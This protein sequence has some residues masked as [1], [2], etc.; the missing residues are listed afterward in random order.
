MA[1]FALVVFCHVDNGF[2]PGW[3]HHQSTQEVWEIE[4]T[5][6]SALNGC[7]V[8]GCLVVIGFRLAL[9]SLVSNVLCWMSCVACVRSLAS[10]IGSLVQR[11]AEL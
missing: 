9:N 6:C 2:A 1:V 7:L 5:S 3:Y 4:P 11:A 10:D 8:L